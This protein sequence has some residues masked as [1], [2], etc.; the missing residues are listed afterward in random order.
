MISPAFLFVTHADFTFSDI[1]FMSIIILPIRHFMPPYAD[2][3]LML[4]LIFAFLYAAMPYIARGLLL[5]I[6]SLRCHAVTL[7]KMLS[8]GILKM[9]RTPACAYFAIAFSAIA[10]MSLFAP[11]GLPLF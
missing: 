11:P 4:S 7:I 1:S 10:L 5:I 8:R 6:T 2:A 9:P 3:A